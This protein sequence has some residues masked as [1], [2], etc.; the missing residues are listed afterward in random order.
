MKLHHFSCIT[1]SRAAAGLTLLAV[2]MISRANPALAQNGR[3]GQIHIV[4]DCSTFSGVPGSSYCQ[5]T[6]SDLPEL[7][8]G[9]KI[10]YDQI[11]GGPTA[12]VAGFLDSNVFIYISETQ[13]AVGRCTVPNDALPGLCTIYDGVG[14]LAGF[15]ARIVVTYKPGGDGALYA[16]DGTF[17]FS[18]LPQR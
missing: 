3:N 15:S 13:W 1:V 10:Y 9:T 8:A 16:W 14:P 17:S 2:S 7:P 4:K 5:I 6:T 11:S 12:G 18:S